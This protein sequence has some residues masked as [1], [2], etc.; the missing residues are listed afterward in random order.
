MPSTCGKRTRKKIGGKKSDLKARK[1]GKFI[2][3]EKQ[4]RWSQMDTTR[5]ARKAN[6]VKNFLGERT[7]DEPT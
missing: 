4:R 7:I 3:A 5:D 6:A 2:S 1:E